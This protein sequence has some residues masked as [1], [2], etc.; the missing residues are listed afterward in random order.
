MLNATRDKVLPTTITGSYPRPTWF[1]EVL[2][3]RAFKDALG[4]SRFREQYLDAVACL[5]AEQTRAGLDIVTDGD[6]RFDLTVGGKSWFFYPIER[7]RGITGHVD[8]STA[9]GWRSIRPGHILYE[10]M[11]AYQPSIVGEKIAGGSLE[12]AALYKTAQRLS[13]RP[14]KFGA[15]SAQTLAKMLVNRHYASERELILDIADVFNA[16]LRAVAAAGC[17]VIQVE[18]PRHHIS[19]AD[20]S[21]SDKDL[22]FFT[23]AINREIAGIDTE[24]WLHTCWG[25]P[26]QQ[27]LHWE[28]P[29]YE[30]AL[31]YLLQTNADAI[32]LECASTG[33]KDLPLLGRYRTD[34]KIVIGV[35]SHT[36]TAVEPPEVVANLIR[37]ALEHVPPERLILSTD[38]GFGREGL[39]RRIAFYKC[40]A[41]NLGANIVRRELK[42][43]EVPVP[44]ADPRFT[45][46][47]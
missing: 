24:V 43:P 36:M 17:P 29:S 8:T 9:S 16:E 6:S 44:A 15:I 22:Q 23:D 4:D 20:G 19:G 38:C 41:I 12:Y 28:R 30:R 25:N 26:N 39:A 32:T 40:V 10:V 2:A 5:V 33:G 14:V 18:E 11:E 31:P 13:E 34:K 7:L 27:P 35:V 46:A 21:A 1:T 42:L 47:G 37:K 3:G 45:L